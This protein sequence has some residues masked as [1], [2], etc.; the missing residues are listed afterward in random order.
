M[1]SFKGHV[2]ECSKV[3]DAVRNLQAVL[4]EDGLRADKL[5]FNE[6]NFARLMA[7]APEL[8]STEPKKGSSEAFELASEVDRSR[9]LPS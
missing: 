1:V 7:I 5:V 4:A 2:H 9:A 8:A 3:K 6:R